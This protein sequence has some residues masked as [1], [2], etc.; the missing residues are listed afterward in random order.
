MPELH[1]AGANRLLSAL[2]AA[3]RKRLAP[4][5]HPEQVELKQVLFEPG[6]RIDCVY[7][8]ATAVVSILTTMDDGTGV[9]I[10]TV[11]NEG[12]VGVPLFLGSDFMPVREFSQAQVPGEVMRMDAELFGAEM[13]TRGSLHHVMQRYVLAFFSQTSQQVACNSLHTIEE[14]CSRW[15]LLTHDRVGSDEFPLT[16]EFLSEMLG[17]RRASVTV[18]A[19]ILAK[20]GFIRFRQG[21]MTIVDR[22]GLEESSCECYRITRAEF[23]RLLGES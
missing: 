21:R 5:V 19:G 4:H 3:D 22:A 14:R 23:D 18:V 16:Q 10:A 1:N 13:A 11:G 2:P 7:F 20:A 8:P 15:L 6:K 17:V 9:E 12:M